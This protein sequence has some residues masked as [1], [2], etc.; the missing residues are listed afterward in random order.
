MLREFFCSGSTQQLAFAYVGLIIFVGH[1]VFKAWLKVALNGWYE[2]FYDVVGDNVDLNE[3]GSGMVEKRNDVWNLLV[4]F[5]VIV[6]PTV[7]VHPVAKWI[8][9]VW[10]YTWRVALIRAYLSHWDC[11]AF[12]IEGVAQRVHEDTQRFAEGLY[13]C[14]AILL[15]SVFTLVAFVPVLLQ[16]G[17]DVHP[18]WAT[19]PP[20]LLTIAIVSALGGLGVSMIV[21]RK[22]V[23]LEVANQ[24]VEA[25]LR[26]K[27]VLLEQTPAAICG[28]VSETRE[29]E[30]VNID[31]Q[32]TAKATP[33]LV[34][35]R[36]VLSDM[37]RNYRRI[38]RQFALFNTWLSIYD[39]MMILVPYMLVAPLLFADDQNDR[40]TLGTLV[41]VSNAFG[42]CFDAMAVVSDNWNAVNAWRSVLRRL[43]EF[44]ETIYSRVHFSPTRIVNEL[45][46]MEITSTVE[47]TP[48]NQ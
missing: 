37:W 38:Y 9:S 20:W 45:D 19:W 21:G 44:E 40:I 36:G 23:G 35:M 24:A 25:R 42:R 22:L 16:L 29:T 2:A 10:C 30:F 6:S 33:P 32:P 47:V 18:P 27:L 14:F 17:E 43:R 46:G 48:H 8:G 5:A 31:V 3:L 7:V 15:D 34:A 41:K 12:P 26:T 28:G 11:G 39:Q 4:D 13:S 1:A